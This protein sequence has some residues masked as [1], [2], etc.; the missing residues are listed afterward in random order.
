MREEEQKATP[1]KEKIM[2]LEVAVKEE[3]EQQ[4]VLARKAGNII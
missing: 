3:K 1:V 2:R 4:V